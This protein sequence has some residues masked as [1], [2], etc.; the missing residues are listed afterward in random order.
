MNDCQPVYQ[1]ASA[2]KGFGVPGQEALDLLRTGAHSCTSS[3]LCP[4]MPGEVRE[5]AGVKGKL[6]WRLR[7]LHFLQWRPCPS[8]A[9]AL[10]SDST[11]RVPGNR[12]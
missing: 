6:D 5:V 12:P 3:F 7:G 4:W 2:P 10:T 8:L 11:R 1:N 9:P